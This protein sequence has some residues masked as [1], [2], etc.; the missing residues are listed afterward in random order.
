M[1]QTISSF[2]VTS[3]PFAVSATENGDLPS[4]YLVARRMGNRGILA[5]Y[6]SKENPARVC[7]VCDEPASTCGCPEGGTGVPDLELHRGDRMALPATGA[8]DLRLRGGNGWGPKLRAGQTELFDHRAA[9]SNSP[10]EDQPVVPFRRNLQR[11]VHDQHD[12]LLSR[13]FSKIKVLE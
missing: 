6:V 2:T 8:S 10:E 1:G 9:L 7:C 3:A 11:D 4:S 12:H 13:C 5:A